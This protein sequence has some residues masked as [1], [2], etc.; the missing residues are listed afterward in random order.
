MKKLSMIFA[1]AAVVLTSCL[2]EEN[3][4]TPGVTDKNDFEPSGVL[5]EK[6]FTAGTSETKTYIDGEE[7]SNGKLVI[8]WCAD[9][10]IN[11]WD[12]VANRKFEMVGVPNGNQAT[13]KGMVDANATDF[14]AVYP[15]DENFKYTLKSNGDMIFSLDRPSVQ[16]ANPEGGLADGAVV[17]EFSTKSR[18]EY[19]IYTDKRIDAA[20]KR[21]V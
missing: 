2:K 15:Y 18:D 6:V 21:N 4:T 12:G 3:P 1:M 17:S 9:D 16:Y 7:T 19:D 13:F 8:K 11:V 10:A 14:Y 20:G 5:V